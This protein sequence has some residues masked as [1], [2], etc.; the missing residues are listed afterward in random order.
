MKT[1]IPVP[2]ITI[3]VSSGETFNYINPKIF[4]KDLIFDDEWKW[5]QY[6]ELTFIEYLKT[7]AD[8]C[9]GFIF[10]KNGRWIAFSDIVEVSIE[11]D[12]ENYSY[13]FIME[14]GKDGHP[15]SISL[16]KKD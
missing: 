1:F 16:K 10:V 3:K 7:E 5:K 6:D 11:Q 9:L 13:V 4:V 14:D 12:K 15:K 8:I 2:A